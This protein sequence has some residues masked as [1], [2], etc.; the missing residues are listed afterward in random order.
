MA[1]EIAIV[2][3][4]SQTTQ[5]IGRNFRQLGVPVT[6]YHPEEAYQKILQDRP[7]GLVLSGGPASV[8]EP[9]A[10]FADPRI[11]DQGIPTL[12]LCFGNQWIA[13]QLG[14]RVER[15]KEEYGPQTFLKKVAHPLLDIPKMRS[16]VYLSHGDTI[17]KLP[18][19]FEVIGSTPG[20]EYSA[21]A[22]DQRRLYGVQFH[23]EVRHTEF[24]S[25]ILKNFATKI[26][27]LELS[28]VSLDP[29]RMIDTIR[30]QVGE[31]RV[32][33][34]VS[35]GVDSTVA[36]FLIGKAIGKNLVPVYV[37]SGLMRPGTLERV[38]RVFNGLVQ[39]ELMVVDGH[40]RFLSALARV[41]NPQRKRLIIG[42][43]YSQML[44]EAANLHQPVKFLAQG[45][46]FSDVIESKGSKHAST[47][48][49]HHNV[50]GLP[51]RIRER[52]VILEPL[53][54]LYKD[55]ARIFGEMSGLPAEVIKQHPFPGPG[56]AIRMIGAVTEA[57][58]QKVARADAIVVEEFKKAGLY[59]Q[60][61]Q[62][63]AVLTGVKTTAVKGDKGVYAEM[64]AIRAHQSE[65]VMTADWFYPPKE[66]LQAI[67]SRIVNEIDGVSRVTYDTTTKPPATM[68]WE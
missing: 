42:D 50:G 35:G 44:E 63:F 29:E 17:T 58:L 28:P 33:C 54:N 52:F 2:D 24:G 27:M 25:E 12:G 62:C 20:V 4:G 45:T 11:L 53:R 59:D 55:Q 46:I 38:Q 61:F 36:A 31:D 23:P 22:N 65:D 6:Y 3:F 10:P 40:R 16:Q 68:E 41:S 51:Q 30:E 26:C 48:K 57:R 43:L 13:W 67:T 9:D 32:I 34:A 1:K 66:L 39:T 60:V 49:F 14:G 8:Y 47:I 64:V 18:E 21:V 56:F 5:L 7:A 15:C 19:G 37:D